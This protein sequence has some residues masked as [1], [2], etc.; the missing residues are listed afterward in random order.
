MSSTSLVSGNTGPIPYQ[1]LPETQKGH[2][3]MYA[4]G[5]TVTV[6]AAGAFVAA[7]IATF[8]FSGP[9][10]LIA[11]GVLSATTYGIINDQLA[12]R[13]CI[14]YFTVGHTQF[15]KRLL[16]TDNPTLNGIVWGIHATWVLGAIAGVLM[17]TAALATGLAVSTI[18]PFLL[19][20]L[21][22]GIAGVCTYSHI[23]AK[24]K[25]AFWKRP[26]NREE[27]NM[28]FQNKVIPA[29]QGF[30]DVYLDD[31]PEDQRAAYMG[32]GERNLLGYKLMPSLGTVGIVGI[33]AAG[34]LL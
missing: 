1:D 27:L 32:V 8:P 17:A 23:K 11:L 6:L 18:M 33:I 10:S 25:E 15:H 2:P 21:A 3:G 7:N 5:V 4:L 30:H 14:H 12:C 31:I 22:I 24:Q 34:I 9:I 20:A 13:Q 29:R 16:A 28:I 19:P 26:E